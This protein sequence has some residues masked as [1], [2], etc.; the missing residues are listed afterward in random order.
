MTEQDSIDLAWSQTTFNSTCRVI[1]RNSSGNVTEVGTGVLIADRWVLTARHLFGTNSDPANLTC[2]FEPFPGGSRTGKISVNYS[3]RNPDIALIQLA[4]DAPAWVP[5]V[6]PYQDSDEVTGGWVF[7]KVGY[8]GIDSAGSQANVRRACTNNYY[9][10]SNDWVD[11]QRDASGADKTQ[12]EGGTAPGDS[13]GPAFLLKNGIW[14]VSSITNGA[15]ADVGFRQVRVSTRM[16]WIRS[17]TGLPFNPPLV[18]ET[19][20]LIFADDFET[21]SSSLD[22][23]LTTRQSG[24]WRDLNG[25]TS[26]SP[27][28]WPV[29]TITTGEQSTR[30]LYLEGSFDTSSAAQDLPPL[31]LTN[32]PDF[33]AAGLGS[34]YE[35]SFDIAYDFSG[36]FGGTADNINIK[37][38]TDASAGRSSTA[39]FVALTLSNNGFLQLGG[40]AV[41]NITGAGHLS[42][43]LAVYDRVRIRIDE[44]AG[45]A[46]ILVNGL[47]AISA[48]FTPPASAARE[49]RLD[50]RANSVNA[51]P[52][53]YRLSLDNL[54][55]AN[56]TAAEPPP[57]VTTNVS[58]GNFE[59][60]VS[61][62]PGDRFDVRR[63]TDLLSFGPWRRNVPA[64]EN[65][66][67]TITDQ[68]MTTRPRSFYQIIRR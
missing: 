21:Q 61:S 54:R 18:P 39:H 63:A 44:E 49:W 23:D 20:V 1:V 68:E 53:L 3:T 50:G 9:Q 22:A 42:E 67:T 8:G 35:L 59:L 26:Y 31:R 58:A 5:R 13:G 45:T 34:A 64:E 66:V 14:F 19:P 56:F 46:A 16:A 6:P 51:S 57:F 33:T 24:A 11:F 25:T 12:W 15:V 7:T 62:D 40:S 43:N 10:E 28:S 48:T 60:H 2:Q 52:K 29:A 30:G 27:G 47:T 4:S 65:G 37:L 55:L 32:D 17:T 36:G 41:T 38:S